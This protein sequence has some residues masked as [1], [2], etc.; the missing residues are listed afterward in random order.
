MLLHET[1]WGGGETYKKRGLKM[2]LKLISRKEM[3]MKS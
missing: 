1:E 3:L 2:S